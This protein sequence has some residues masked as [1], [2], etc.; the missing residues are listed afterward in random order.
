MQIL[1]NNY[2]KA[3]EPKTNP[4]VCEKCESK[5]IIDE[6]D[7]TVGAFGCYGWTCPC[8]GDWNS[9]EKSVDLTPAD[10]KYPQHF[11]SYGNGVQLSD[12]EITSMVRSCAD[13]LDKNNDFMLSAT[14][15]TLV[16]A[17]KSDE[18]YSEAT[19]VVAKKYQETLVQIPREKF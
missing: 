11:A 12:D 19:V 15:N 9:I 14:G 4:N 13:Q 3:P 17:Y 10:V 8:C 18:D 7:L 2:N 16:L 1:E 6:A 5:L